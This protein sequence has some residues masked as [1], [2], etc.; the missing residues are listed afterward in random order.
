M[1]ISIIAVLFAASWVSLAPLQCGGDPEYE[2]RTT[3][4]PGEALYGL[5]KRFESQGN[6]EAWS[7]T[8]KYLIER[9]PNSRF[10]VMAKDDL[11]KQ[12]AR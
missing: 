7:A 10:A 9:Y 4:T 6:R 5:A 8:L 12:P 3:E 11:E 2:L 1:R